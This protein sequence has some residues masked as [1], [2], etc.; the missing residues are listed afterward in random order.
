MLSHGMSCREQCF[1]SMDI[2]DNVAVVAGDRC[3][4]ALHRA[5][6]AF[7]SGVSSRTDCVYTK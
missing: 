3:L 2:G 7:S 6:D 1:Q 4:H 5:T